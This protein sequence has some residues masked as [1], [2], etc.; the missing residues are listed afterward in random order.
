MLKTNPAWTEGIGRGK[1]SVKSKPNWT[2]EFPK[3][4]EVETPSKV[5]GQVWDGN[6]NR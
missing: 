3:T 6:K 2:A 5:E 4:E 1:K